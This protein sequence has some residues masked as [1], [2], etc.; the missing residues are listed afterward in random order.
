[1]TDTTIARIAAASMPTHETQVEALRAIDRD[2]DDPWADEY[3]YYVDRHGCLWK[4]VKR[5]AYVR[6]AHSAPAYGDTE[7][8]RDFVNRLHGPLVRVD[9]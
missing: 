6:R 5:K 3:P 8:E 9:A 1:M 4:D 7:M 2:L